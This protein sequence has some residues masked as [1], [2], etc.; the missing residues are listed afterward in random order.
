[1]NALRSVTTLFLLAVAC[2]PIGTHPTWEKACGGSVTVTVSAITLGD[3]CGG[4]SAALRAPE[5]GDCAEGGCS[6]LCRQSSVQLDIVSTAHTASTFEVRQVRLYDPDNGALVD[7]LTPS[8][9]K[10]WVNNQYQSW[11]QSIGAGSTVKASYKLSA[12][13]WN[14]VQD[15]SGRFGYTKG[16]KTQVDVAVDGEL[17]TLS[18]PD[19]YREPEVAT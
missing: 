6:F 16:Y 9:P 10:H 8:D 12:P 4:G 17:R 5:A 15:A 7:I 13:N 18:G 3:D 1:M 14:G 19:A 2:G 11:N